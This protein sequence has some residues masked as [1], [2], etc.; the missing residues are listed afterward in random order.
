M[1]GLTDTHTHL[2]LKEFDNDRDLVILRAKEAGVTRMFMSNIDE[3][4]IKS[5]LELCDSTSGCYPLIGLHP[6]SVDLDWASRLSKVEKVLR[7]GRVFYGIGEVGIDLYWD[8][9]YAERQKQVF[10]I[11]LE[12]A[13]EFNLPLIIHCRNAHKEIL[14]VM[15]PYKDTPL[16]GIFHCFGG[17]L[18]EANDLLSYKN[19][20]IGINGIVTF[21][22]NIL[23]DTLKH[24]PLDRIVLETDSP[25]LAPVP[26]R[27]E[28]NE[29]AYI[30]LVANK[31]ADILDI[32]LDDIARHTTTNALKVFQNADLTL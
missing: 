14:D 23:P 13:L 1:T 20:M 31:L 8:K 15:S 16:R 7:S 28:R 6:T 25:Y 22:K 26:H 4:S 29:S 3:T 17:S 19:F 30:L 2:F 32:S 18:E 11:Q 21:K 12:W 24:L 5:L 10:K 9:T 27:G